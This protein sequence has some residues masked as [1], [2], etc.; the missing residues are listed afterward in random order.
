MKPWMTATDISLI[1][2]LLL[3]LNK[4]NLNIL[5]WGSG[6]STKYF[7]GFLTSKGIDYN[8]L[9]LE[10]NGAWCEKIAAFHI[11]NTTIVLFDVGNTNLKQRYTNMDDYIRYPMNLDKKFDFILVDGRKRRRCLLNASKLLNAGGVVVLHDAERTY[12]HSAFSSYKT[13]KFLSNTL[14]MGQ[15]D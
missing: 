8:W 6:G 15:N 7:T 1:E 3:D 9:S 14:W 12:Y 10:Y 5:E 4:A 13:S 2:K 11:P